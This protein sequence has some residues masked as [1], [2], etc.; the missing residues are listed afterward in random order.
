MISTGKEFAKKILHWFPRVEGYLRERRRRKKFS[1]ELDLIQGGHF[2]ENRL[3]SIMQFSFNKAA[4]QY[5][6]NILRRC[7]AHNG[8]VN[9][10]I[11]GYAFDT[12]YPFFDKLSADE[13]LRYRHIFKPAGYFYGAF[14]GMIE[15]IAGL[16]HYKVIL[17]TRDPR[18]ILVSY[19]YSMAYSHP[20]PSQQGD[21]FD[22]FMDLRRAALEAAL[23][24]YAV[25]ES[26]KLCGILQRYKVLLLDKYP[27]VYITSYENMISDFH[28]WLTDLLN[29]CDVEISDGFLRSLIEENERLRPK[30]ENVQ[31]HIRKG[32]HGD[33]KNKLRPDTIDYL[34]KKFSPFYEVFGYTADGVKLTAGRQF[35]S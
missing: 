7:A 32:T 6:K 2:N 20:V 19:Y 28:G 13:M 34:N 31:K 12:E 8:M 18:D 29:Y 16:D 27:H 30:K 3:S 24:D 4:T 14:G 17:M 11:S 22:G 26:D 10:D 9:V 21:K 25:A 35:P 33:Y 1:V 5:T 23:D 15:G